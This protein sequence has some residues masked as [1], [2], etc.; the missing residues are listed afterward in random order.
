MPY[1]QSLNQSL[2]WEDLL[3][4][5]TTFCSTEMGNL[6]LILAVCTAPVEGAATTEEQYRDYKAEYARLKSIIQLQ[7]GGN[8]VEKLHEARKVC[9]LLADLA[10]EKDFEGTNEVPWF[11]SADLEVGC[12]FKT[13]SG[14]STVVSYDDMVHN[15]ENDEEPV[16]GDL[17]T[18]VVIASKL[19]KLQKKHSQ[20]KVTLPTSQAIWGTPIGISSEAFESVCSIIN[21][22]GE[23]V[24]VLIKDIRNIDDISTP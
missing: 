21:L 8:P 5:E 17:D 19:H 14:L 9:R 13:S 16:Y 11:A 12:N 1:P 3:R 15:L 18:L 4:I 7:K 24:T 6:L 23:V 10:V 20:I 22:Q 2:H